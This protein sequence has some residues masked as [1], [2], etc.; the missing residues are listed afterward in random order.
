[1]N[2]RFIIKIENKDFVQYAG[3]LDLGHQKGISQIE[4]DPIQLPT[5]DN[6]NFA[7]CKATVISKTG[8][9]F[10]DIGDANPQNCNSKVSRA[11]FENGQHQSHRS[12]TSQFHQHWD[13]LLGGII[14]SQ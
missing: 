9:S 2:E 1:M 11:S 4:V 3:L 14:R 7:I 13:D 6:G 12:G 8:D 10:T 5:Q